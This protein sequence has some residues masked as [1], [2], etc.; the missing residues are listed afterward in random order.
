MKP[1]HSDFYWILSAKIRLI[2]VLMSGKLGVP[3][4]L[5][6]HFNLGNPPWTEATRLGTKKAGSPAFRSA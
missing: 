4:A 1:I 3:D 6:V 5:Q 2:R